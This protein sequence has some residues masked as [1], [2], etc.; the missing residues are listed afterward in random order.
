MRLLTNVL[1]L[2]D[3]SGR[4]RTLSPPLPPF[5]P[6]QAVGLVGILVSRS[7]ELEIAVGTVYGLDNQLNRLLRTLVVPHP[8]APGIRAYALALNLGGK[9]FLPITLWAL[10]LKHRQQEDVEEKASQI[11]GLGDLSLPY[12]FSDQ[13]TVPPALRELKEW[14][15]LMDVLFSSRRRASTSQ[16]GLLDFLICSIIRSLCGISSIPLN[17]P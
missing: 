4:S 13:S 12:L 7:R 10:A 3:R 14:K 16:D 8:R 9:W 11:L 1:L 2:S 17:L 15:K 5:R 6:R